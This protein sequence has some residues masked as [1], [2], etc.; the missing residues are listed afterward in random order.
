MAK[1]TRRTP[2]AVADAEPQAVAPGRGRAKKTAPPTDAPVPKS[3]RAKAKQPKAAAKTPK[4]A[5]K[6]AKATPAP[7]A[8]AARTPKATMKRAR[9]APA[10]SVPPAATPKTAKAPAAAATKKT[11]KAPADTDKPKAARRSAKAG[12]ALGS[13]V[14][15]T[16]ETMAKTQRDIPVSEFFA[17]NRHLLGF[18]NPRKA[19]L[20]TIKEAVDNSLDACEEAGISPAVEIRVEQL[21]EAVFRVTVTD[22]GPGIVREQIPNIFGRLL[23]GSKFH[24]MKMARGQQ[25]IGISA[26][27]MYGLLTTGQ[28]V[29]IVSRTGPRKAAHA[30]ELRIDTRCNRP[31]IL[32]DETVEWDRP[33][34][35]SVAIELE[36]RYQKGRASVDEY[37]QQTAIANPHATLVYHAPDGRTERYEATV[38]EPP[39]PAQSVKPH[40]YGVELGVLIRMLHD[41]RYRYLREFLVESFSR[42]T[43]AIAREVLR[44]ANLR[45]KTPCRDCSRAE[46]VRLYET[47]QATTIAPPSTDCI[48]PIGT[49]QLL[50]GLAQVVQA[51]FY[52]AVSRSPVVYRGNPF[53][54]E[55]ALA[56]G[57]GDGRTDPD[58][59]P[60]GEDGNG[61]AD[62][63]EPESFAEE[64]LEAGLAKV[65]RF[66]NRVPLLYQ[67]GAC[68]MTRSVMQT[69]WRTY[70]LAQS[71][72]A[73][74]AGPMTLAV[75][76]AS[77]WVPF[78]SESKEA[79]A[80]YPEI[81][82]EI[83]K[84]LQECGRQLRRYLRKQLRIRE[85]FKKRSYIEK[86]I[87][88]IG[89]ALR[90]IL[91][92]DEPQVDTVVGNLREVLERSRK[93]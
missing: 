47:L 71:R 56:F 51:D 30:Y 8:K 76:M 65:I 5:A 37:L 21:A 89:I 7:K 52:T 57:T 42:V 17:K 6:R 18:D 10:D 28:N 55:V 81:A 24:G 54:I 43:P 85:E 38:A 86:Y 39:P 9:K 50:K 75:H 19:L 48:A 67:Q 69:N 36:A 53:V 62:A 77:V 63:A 45:V 41:T 58:A 84:A 93:V 49:E 16:A 83:R 79:V 88:H 92:L 14:Y 90:D 1:R 35:T 46:A 78:T 22:N 29:K 61:Q 4:T 20:T 13:V 66:A 26:A 25:G 80:E 32:R 40:P 70:G 33:R 23:Y 12:A 15:A 73:L 87:P 3:K 72:G 59:T 82:L 44:K 34:G 68:A 74:P 31:E 64:E 11:R 2:A 91:S 27:G 60:N